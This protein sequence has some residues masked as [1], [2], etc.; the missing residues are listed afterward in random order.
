MIDANQDSKELPD[1]F[2]ERITE[3]GRV[4]YVK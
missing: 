3:E 2:E 4:Y 1:G